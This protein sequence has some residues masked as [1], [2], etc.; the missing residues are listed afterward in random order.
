[1]DVASRALKA[2]AGDEAEAVVQFERSGLARFAGSVQHQP[3]L[4]EN[5]VV[6]LRVVRGGRVGIAVSNRTGDDGLRE[7]AARAGEA[8]SSVRPEEDFPGLATPSNYPEVGG[9]DEE[10]ATLGPE[11]Q[12]RLAAAAIG[13]TG[14]TPAYGFF[15]SGVTELAIASST[16]IETTQRVSDSTLLVLASDV[17]MSGYATQASAAVSDLDP[18]SCGVEAAEKAARTRDAK[19]IEPGPYRAVL[20]P[21]ALAELIQYFSYDSLGALGLLEERSYFAGRIGERV[22]DEK[23]TLYDDALDARGFPKGFDFEGVGKQRVPLAEDGVA[24]GVVWDRRTAKRAGGDAHSTGHAPPV[25][26]QVYG[27]LPFALSMSGGEA[28]SLDELVALVGDGIYVTR[29]HY[30]GIVHPREGVITGMTRDGTFRIRDGKI[31]EPLV[32]LRFTVA[33]PDV[34][35]DVPGLS[36]EVKLVNQS[37]FYG[38]RYPFGFLSPA[39]ATARFNITGVG[40]TPGI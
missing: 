16:G 38:E 11:D 21:Y 18:V 5:T 40:S 17:G 13:A 22:F 4:I 34:L 25:A 15:T 19:E 2:A 12:A 36:R 32:N 29:L 27:P 20:E 1:M 14:G 30:L 9:C 31:A 23:V 37:D 6:T 33:V 10:T 39:I 28:E 24:R 3:T 35:A 8:A 26:L 7:L